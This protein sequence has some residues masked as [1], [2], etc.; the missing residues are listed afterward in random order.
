M[1]LFSDP[2]KIAKL[3][4]HHCKGS[5]R[6]AL[7]SRSHLICLTLLFLVTSS[8]QSVINTTI[9]KLWQAEFYAQTTDLE[10]RFSSHSL[11]NG[12]FLL[13]VESMEFVVYRE[14]VNV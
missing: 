1:A 5:N 7:L 8:L 6:E 10:F 11:V 14:E 12:S 3:L 4:V 9:F 13:A 2:E